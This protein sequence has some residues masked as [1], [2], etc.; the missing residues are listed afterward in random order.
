MAQCG[1]VKEENI[2]IF[3]FASWEPIENILLSVSFSFAYKFK[4][5]INEFNLPKNPFIKLIL[6]NK[7][8]QAR[9][10]Y[11]NFEELLKY[12]DH[13]A[14]PVGELYLALHG[15]KDSTLQELSDF[16]CTGLQLTNFWQDVKRDYLHDRIYIPAEDMAYFNVKES[17]LGRE[18][19]GSNLRALIEYQITRTKQYFEKGTSL[20]NHVRGNEK[21][22]LMLFILGGQSIINAIEKQK[23]D[24]LSKRPKVGNIQKCWIIVKAW[25]SLKL[26]GKT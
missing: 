26:A 9:N 15:Y 18:K 5:T 22:N 10:R 11:D 2:L 25:C 14:N 4:E 20:L 16:V 7:M 24:I 3:T 19:S 17:D 21:L 1:H 13:S 6:A 12:C 8:D 23:F